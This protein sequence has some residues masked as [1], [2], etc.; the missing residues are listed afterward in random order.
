MKSEFVYSSFH[1]FC[2]PSTQESVIEQQLYSRHMSIN[3]LKN[4][5]M[6]RLIARV[7]SPRSS[8]CAE[9]QPHDSEERILKVTTCIMLEQRLPL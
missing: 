3:K 1:P 9:I 7:K 6:A 5:K 4:G 2:N 8:N